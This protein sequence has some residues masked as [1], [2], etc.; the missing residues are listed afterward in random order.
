MMHGTPVVNSLAALDF[1]EPCGSYRTGR[2]DVEV[3]GSA[4]S[5]PTTATRYEVCGLEAIDVMSLINGR[6]FIG[7]PSRCH[8][9][10]C[11]EIAK[12]I[13]ASSA[14]TGLWTAYYL[15]QADPGLR[16]TVLEARSSPASERPGATAGGCPAWPRTSPAVGQTARPRR[17]HSLAACAQRRRRRGDRGGR[18]GA[19]RRRHRQGRHSGHRPQPAGAA[20]AGRRRRGPRLGYRRAYTAVGCRDRRADHRRR[21]GTGGFT[22]HCARIQLAKLAR[23]LADVVE[24][25]GVA[26]YEQ[27]PWSPISGPARR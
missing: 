22:P 8:G 23:G 10:D 26:V 1:G 18:P 20:A 9:Q 24:R 21:S 17:R 13:S 6:V 2:G 16:I 14:Y 4:P 15:K 25:L 11:R 5:R 3:P 27:T 7:S 12:P 19:D